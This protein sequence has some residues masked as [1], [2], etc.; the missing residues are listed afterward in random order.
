M[1]AAGQSTVSVWIVRHTALVWFGIFLNA[2]FIIPLLFF[3]RWMLDLFSIPLEQLIW[4]RESAGLLM[5]ISAFYVPAAVDFG[6][7]RANAYIAIFPSRTF[8]ATFF[9]FA[10][11]L[12]GQPPGFLSISFVDAFI[13]STT[14]YCLLRIKALERQ[15]SESGVIR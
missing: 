3:P 12:F 6:R 8:G 11:V 4:A 7:Y 10:V 5:I 14:F 15:H 2:L 13:G 9:F 1:K